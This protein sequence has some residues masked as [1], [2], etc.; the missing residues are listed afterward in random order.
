VKKRSLAISGHRTSVSLE[1]PFWDALK[2]IA[3]EQRRSIASLVAEIDAKRGQHP[4]SSALRL[5][6]LEHYRG[7][8]GSSL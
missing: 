1:T 2:E 6:V 5:H 8:A 4:L 3:E 7:K